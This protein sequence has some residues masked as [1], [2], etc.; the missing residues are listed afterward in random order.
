MQK[1]ELCQYDVNIKYCTALQIIGVGGEH[2][3]TLAVFLELSDPQKW[4][5]QFAVL[6]LPELQAQQQAAEEE[7]EH[8]LGD[9]RNVVLKHFLLQDGCSVW[10]ISPK[11]DV[12]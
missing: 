3:A 1:S 9:D 10:A 4:P 5:R 11:R 12:P 2:A 7:V 6:D 8:T